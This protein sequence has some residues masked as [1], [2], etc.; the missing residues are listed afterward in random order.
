MKATYHGHS[1]VKVEANGK[2]ILFDP[3]ISENGN[4]DLNADEVKADVILLT[5][6]HNDHVGDTV[7]IAKRNDALVVAPFELATYLGNKGVNAHPMYIGGSHEFDFGKVKFTQ[8]FHGSSYAEEDGTIVY[9]GMPTGILLTVE[10]KTIFHAGDTGLFS[11]MK[12]IGEMNDIELAFLP[13]GD[14]FTMGPDDALVAAKWLDAKQVVPIHYN[15]F[16][17]INQ[18]GKAFAEKVSPGTGKALEVGESIEL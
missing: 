15:T 4:T 11:D 6:G 12:M 16:D 5:H 2:T 7:D 3:F 10:G 1:V 9:T 17:L 13:I 18:D 8:A 14:N